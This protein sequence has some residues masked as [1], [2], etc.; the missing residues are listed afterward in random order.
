[1]Y[2]CVYIYIYIYI[3]EEEGRARGRARPRGED[4]LEGVDEHG[5]VL[6]SATTKKE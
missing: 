4:A 5:D 6:T 3:F 2:V 1:M